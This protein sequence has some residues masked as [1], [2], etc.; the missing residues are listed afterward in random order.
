MPRNE[1]EFARIRDNLRAAHDSGRSARA[2]RVRVGLGMFEQIGRL[3]AEYA[4]Q[5]REAIGAANEDAKE[6]NGRI[7]E[8]RNQRREVLAEMRRQPAA[9]LRGQAQELAETASDKS[10]HANDILWEQARQFRRRFREKVEQG[11]EQAK[12]TY[13][14]VRRGRKDM[15]GVLAQ[16]IKKREQAHDLM[17]DDSRRRLARED[18]EGAEARS[19]QQREQASALNREARAAFYQAG[20]MQREQMRGVVNQI[21]G[22]V[23]GAFKRAWRDAS[24]ALLDAGDHRREA[25]EL[26]KQAKD[27][28]RVAKKLEREHRKSSRAARGTGE[29]PSISRPAPVSSS[30]SMVDPPHD[31]SGV[32]AARGAV[33]RAVPPRGKLAN[34]PLLQMGDPVGGR[35]PPVIAAPSPIAPSHPS[36]DLGTFPTEAAPARAV[37]PISSR[38]SGP[39]SQP[40]EPI[41]LNEMPAR[42]AEVERALEARTWAESPQSHFSVSSGGSTVS[43]SRNSSVRSSAS[44]SVRSSSDSTVSSSVSSSAWA[45]AMNSLRTSL[46]APPQSELAEPAPHEFEAAARMGVAAHE[47]PSRPLPSHSYAEHQQAVPIAVD[48]ALSAHSSPAPSLSKIDLGPKLGEELRKSFESI[49]QKYDTRV[50]AE[51]NRVNSR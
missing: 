42:V 6:A 46:Y 26:R 21:G 35:E 23:G 13:A 16:A 18:G 5:A 43:S 33:R 8:A 37:S 4:V 38:D 1:T 19:Q 34:R 40:R 47:E 9:S 10:Q 12:E 11:R 22:E 27:F 17:R 36:L 20:Q 31:T 44:A 2:R 45:T 3:G 14:E 29:R 41:N 30:N 15:Y 48:E 24:Q 7:K 28:S 25:A 39:L 50:R 51:R 32:S 49:N